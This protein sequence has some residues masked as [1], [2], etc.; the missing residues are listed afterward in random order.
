MGAAYE[1]YPFNRE[2][3][4]RQAGSGLSSETFS[5]GAGSTDEVISHNV[6]LRAGTL[7]ELLSLKPIGDRAGAT[8]GGT[9][10]PEVVT[11][12]ISIELPESQV[13][14]L[15][16]EAKRLGVRSED[17]AAAAVVDLL[18]RQAADFDSAAKHVLEKNRELYQRLS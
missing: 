17:L 15:R 3:L 18:N 16:G 9:I 8:P 6:E 10:W 14:K 12:R 2:D 5:S 13:D 1:G 7:R 4:P 11:M